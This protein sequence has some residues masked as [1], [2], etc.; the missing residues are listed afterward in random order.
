MFDLKEY[1][2]GKSRLVDAYLRD[3]FLASPI[4]P[5]FF[6]ESMEYSIKA[7]GKRLR[8]VLA[9]AS[10]EASGGEKPE[11]ILRYACALELIHTYSLIHDDLPA[12]D[13]DDLR[14]GKPTNHKVYG[15]A[16]AILAGDGLLTEAF[17]ML[18]VPEHGINA[19]ALLQVIMDVARRAGL[20]GMVA[21]QAQDILSEQDP[22]GWSSESASSGGI[23]SG[24]IQS[25]ND[26]R[27]HKSSAASREMIH[28]IHMHKTSQLIT[29]S[30]R[31]GGML[32]GTIP[33]GLEALTGY[34]EA[35]GL[36]FQVADDILDVKGETALMGKTAGSDERKNKF[37]YP[38]V[39]GLEA[40]EQE[41]RDLVGKAI[42][43]LD[44]V[45]G[46]EAEPLREI[47]RYIV[48]RKN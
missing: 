24:D 44:G 48:E 37:T 26:S 17:H 3:Y 42:S 23:P 29:A 18:S 5:A 21:G 11:N 47:A 9:L 6:K 15:E 1:L 30:V 31:M 12:M 46:P 14:R 20:Y 39:Y 16:M 4:K 25:D 10:Y 13:D 8:P 33:A 7:G 35:V 28:F 27:D 34:G 2:A 32:A 41:A 43:A 40:S 19:D 22:K 38:S 45:F 36:A